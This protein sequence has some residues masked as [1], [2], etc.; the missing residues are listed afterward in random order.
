MAPIARA[1]ITVT[2]D[3][4]GKQLLTRLAA[5]GPIVT[6]AIDHARFPTPETQ[7]ELTEAVNVYL[8]LTDDEEQGAL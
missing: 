4:M 7:A 1:E 6:A 5:V 2:L 3:D 8:K